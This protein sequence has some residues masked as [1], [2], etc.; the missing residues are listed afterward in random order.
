MHHKNHLFVH[1][2]ASK[3]VRNDSYSIGCKWR[4]LGIIAFLLFSDMKMVSNHS[5]IPCLFCIFHEPEYFLILGIVLLQVLG[6]SCWFLEKNLCPRFHEVSWMCD[7]CLEC[8]II[9][10]I[11][12]EE[13][14]TGK[15]QK[16]IFKIYI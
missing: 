10:Y 3:H 7:Q 2:F 16:S 11:T 14:S 4:N 1:K 13:R 15:V 9:T 12:R 5:W 6:D 8:N